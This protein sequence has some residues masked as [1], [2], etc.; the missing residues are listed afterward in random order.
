M[1]E[2]WFFYIFWYW[3]VTAAMSSFACKH[4]DAQISHAQSTKA[5]VLHSMNHPRSQRA[6]Q[7]TILDTHLVAG[8]GVCASAVSLLSNGE[9]DTLA[10]WQ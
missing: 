3:F 6:S 1:G 10:L 2:V 8:N 7:T 4:F 9:L 5:P